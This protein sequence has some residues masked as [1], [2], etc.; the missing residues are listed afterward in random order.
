MK[1]LK[2][3]KT[4]IALLIAVPVSLTYILFVALVGL[5]DREAKE[6]II[7]SM[8]NEGGKKWKHVE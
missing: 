3:I 4:T 6:I 8:F 5:V 1:H 7:A 2:H